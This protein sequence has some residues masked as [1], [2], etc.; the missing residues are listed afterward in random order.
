MW[1]SISQPAAS[2]K[3]HTHQSSAA[4]VFWR[5]AIPQGHV[6]MKFPSKKKFRKTCSWKRKKKWLG[7]KTKSRLSLLLPSLPLRLLSSVHLQHHLLIIYPKVSLQIALQPTTL[8][9]LILLSTDSC[10]RLSSASFSLSGSITKKSIFSL[11]IDSS[12]FHSSI[13]HNVA[14][15]RTRPALVP[16]RCEVTGALLP[17]GRR[18]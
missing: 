3:M 7:S 9:N 14:S 12:S 8:R 10:A 6:S 4:G 11:G 18:H 1:N 13:T 5:V 17:K 15:H 16:H 2:P